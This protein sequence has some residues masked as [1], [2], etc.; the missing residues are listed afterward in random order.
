MPNV[1]ELVIINRKSQNIPRHLFYSSFAMSLC[2][3]GVCMY[4]CMYV[5]TYMQLFCH[6]PV[7]FRHHHQ[8]ASAPPI[9]T[10]CFNPSTQAAIF[11]PA[12]ILT[13]FVRHHTALAT[14]SNPRKTND[15]G[16]EVAGRRSK[17]RVDRTIGLQ[18]RRVPCSGCDLTFATRD[19]SG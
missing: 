18:G 4:V 2:M 1:L 19:K 9:H 17:S 8:K 12:P 14:L 13:W 5:C 3:R 16:W 10:S 7:L 15:K 6:S 11:H